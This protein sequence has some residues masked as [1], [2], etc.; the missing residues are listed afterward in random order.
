VR[1]HVQGAF[2]PEEILFVGT[3]AAR[4]AM[5]DMHFVEEGFS[6]IG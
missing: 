6:L 3:Q 1:G 5:P 4:L 2:D